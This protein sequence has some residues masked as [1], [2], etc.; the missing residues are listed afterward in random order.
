MYLALAILLN[1]DVYQ[2]SEL[3]HLTPGSVHFKF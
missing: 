1:L 2:L 3:T